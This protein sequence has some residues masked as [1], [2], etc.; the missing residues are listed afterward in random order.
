VLKQPPA[1][2]A[3]RKRGQG[4]SGEGCS[5]G[6]GSEPNE[7]PTNA[8]STAS[9]RVVS[10]CARPTPEETSAS[11]RTRAANGLAAPQR[12]VTFLSSIDKVKTE[13]SKA[14][15]PPPGTTV[16]ASVTASEEELTTTG[17]SNGQS[18]WPTKS[19]DEVLC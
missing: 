6:C 13:E 12:E 19:G 7:M 4:A 8:K 9:A 15:T 17:T 11:E 5:M 16:T 10:T 14:T 2:A 1:A 18:K 3:A